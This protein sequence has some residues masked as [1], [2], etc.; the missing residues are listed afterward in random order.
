VKAGV[1]LQLPLNT[2]A[3]ADSKDEDI[4]ETNRGE[5]DTAKKRLD[6]NK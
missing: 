4:I 3:N 2:V 6:Q 1:S 5:Y